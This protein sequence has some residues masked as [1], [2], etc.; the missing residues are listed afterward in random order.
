MNA[1]IIRSLSLLFL[2]LFI[3]RGVQAQLGKITI[4]LEKDKPKKFESQTLRSEKTGNKKFTVPR[5][6]VQNT[7][8]HY[9]YFYN[10][11]SKI[12]EVIERA[13]MA[14]K[15]DYTRLLP[16][17]SYSL[18]NTA[19]QKSDLDSVIYKATAGILIHDLRTNW[20]DNFYLLIGEAY[21]LR[22]DFDS[23]AMTFQFINYNL[24]PHKKKDDDQLIVGSNEYG[25]NSA[26]SISSKESRKLTDKVFTRPPS[27]NDAFI[28]RIRTL[29]DMNELSDA[30]G[31]INTLQNDPD[32]PGRLKPAL[33][34]VTA[35]W[36]FS[37]QMYDSSLA[38]LKNSM[39]TTLDEED[40]ARREFLMA[41]LYEQTNKPDDASAYYDKA[42]HHTANPLMDIY[43]NLNKATM[44]RSH[45]PAEIDKSIANLLQM[46]KKDR[47]EDYRDL[48]YYSAAKI[49]LIKPDTSAAVALFK[50]ST[51]YSTIDNIE[52]KD[53]AFLALADI[54]YKQKKYQDAYAFYDSLQL[55]DTALHNVADIQ[56]K[57]AALA[58]IVGY[59]NVIDR[60]DSL[61]AIAAMSPADR[62]AFLK[63]LSKR[64]QKEYGLK[65]D[66][67]SNFSL[68]DRYN[69]RYASTDQ[70]GNTTSTNGE[71]YFYNT[72]LKAQGY[73]DFKRIWGKRENVDNWRRSAAAASSVAA[74]SFGNPDE[75]DT[76]VKATDNTQAL[77]P[78]DVNNF[79]PPVIPEQKD[80]S[81]KGLLE[82][83]PLTKEKMDES[84]T[85]VSKSLF[86][87]GKNYQTKLED[88]SAAID[89]YEKSLKRFPDSLYAGELYLNLSFCYRKLGDNEKADYYK[90]LLVNK[91]AK[92]RF[93]QLA[94]HPE[95]MEPSKKDPAATKR[96]EDIY[97]L[98]IEGN[99]EKA[100]EEKKKAD[101]IY[102]ANYWSPQL[103]YIQSVYYIKKREDSTAISILQQ[104]IN[105]YPA[106]PLKS[107]AVT[108][109][110]VLKRRKQIEAYLTNLKIQREKE[111]T[112]I[113]VYDDPHLIK[114]MVDTTARAQQVTQ[115]HTRIIAQKVYVDSS[116]KAPPPVSNGTFMIDPLSPQNVMMVLT[117]VDP[118][119][120]SEA[121]NAMARYSEENFYSQQITVTKDTLDKDRQLIVFSQFPTADDAI[122]FVNRLKHDAPSEIS[123]L[124]PAKYAFYI[125][126]GPNL[127]LLKQNKNLQSYLDLLN[128][129]YPGKF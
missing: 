21:Y 57:K 89:V 65:N 43:A 95:A 119:Y 44:L 12:K 96:Y 30:A 73:N 120:I 56:K 85:K 68:Q 86:E 7:V 13:R 82:N 31:L 61:Q 4:D 34:E 91:F 75:A 121:K 93:T 24:Y 54:S 90:N 37:Q 116:K 52:T 122:K 10:A 97:N 77:T 18:D 100:V 70:F 62:E 28:W 88:Y 25:P 108:M 113:V 47:F 59:L 106:S 94:L 29:I 60:E 115:D 38:H 72:T 17:Y 99:F 107:K 109:I 80:L 125:I 42:M 14:G 51:H 36:F 102:G 3:F 2:C 45:D 41:Q 48:I 129:K 5:K 101:S 111:D 114:H 55:S 1:R 8:S 11:N 22:K 32:F 19:A 6:F 84:N 124:P 92:S 63:K 26:I 81:V 27:R 35:Y 98:F 128:K 23:A 83:V 112:E 79:L 39:P 69:S 53:K 123:W 71:W 76:T 50:K 66:T 49:A 46:A 9:N 33:E 110:D 64:L 87:L 103:L 127:D 15:D 104:I 40:Q 58:V 118:V 126:S 105:Q 16:F 78:A 67:A 74:N 20:V 117:K